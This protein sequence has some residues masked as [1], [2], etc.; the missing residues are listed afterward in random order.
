M[1]MRLM[2]AQGAIRSP[3]V[4]T[5]CPL[6]GQG[7]TEYL[8]LLAVVL[9]V[10][11]VSV[12]LL[13]FFPGMASDAQITQ[14]KT[15]WQSA[16]PIAIVEMEAHYSTDN[17]STLLYIR[18]RNTGAYPIRI[19]KI[20]GENTNG[21]TIIHN[22]AAT[23]SIANYYYLGPGEENFFGATS[24]IWG[25]G[26]AL[27][28]ARYIDARLIGSCPAAS[29]IFCASQICSGTGAGTFQSNNFGFEYIEYV[30]GQQITKRQIGKPLII[31]CSG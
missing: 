24:A 8:V 29:Y 10:A 7:A 9:V 18:V 21:A 1:G 16:S 11:L 22:G 5:Y 25:G 14:S 28:A 4:A 3:S 15:Y 26:F 31:K 30:E 6:V 13:G 17:P 12:A 23:P 19:T 20:I 2:R 27:P